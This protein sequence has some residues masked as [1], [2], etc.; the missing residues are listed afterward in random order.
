M[1]KKAEQLQFYTNNQ[2]RKADM[3]VVGRV[4]KGAWSWT[5]IEE[6]WFNPL[7]WPVNFL[8]RIAKKS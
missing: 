2:N 5:K 7:P 8:P 1:C 4:V 3:S 6:C